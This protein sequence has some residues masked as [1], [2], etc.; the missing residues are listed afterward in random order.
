M[1]LV[2][3]LVL[4]LLVLSGCGAPSDSESQEVVI[5]TYFE[6]GNAIGLDGELIEDVA[7]IVDGGIIRAIGPKAEVDHPPGA[8]RFD[9]SN[10]TVIPFLH[11]MHGHVG[12]TIGSNFD[13]ANY[14]RE[15][16]VDDLD[17][18]LY[19]GVGSVATLGSDAGELAFQI[20]EE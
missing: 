5:V 9:L 17:R 8:D 3:P 4:L 12:L 14:S 2:A 6:N 13:A 18:Y 20:R 7:I 16:V 19:Y 15:T 11:N 1:K 10:H